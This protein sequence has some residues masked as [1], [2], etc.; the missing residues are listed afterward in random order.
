MKRS[1]RIHA[2][3]TDIMVNRRMVHGP[4]SQGSSEP[5]ATGFWKDTSQGFVKP[6]EKQ[7]GGKHGVWL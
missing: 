2:G 4:A 6:V 1:D 7:S 3:L 5:P